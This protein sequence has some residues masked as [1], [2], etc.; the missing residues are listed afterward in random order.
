MTTIRRSA[1][2]TFT[3]RQMF[4]LVNNIADYP[5]FLPWCRSSRILSQTDTEI[6][7]SLEIAWSGVRKSF[8][9]RN[10]LYPYERID[11]S[12]AEGPFRHLEGHWS[13]I[14]CGESGCQVN[15]A[16]QFE[17]TGHVLDLVF[18]PVFHRIANSLVDAFCK[19]A[20]ELYGSY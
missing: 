10:H 1:L 13:F 5:R 17:L 7:A 15:L 11:I 2:V 20:V 16:L 19:R 3:P 9:T 12:L 8:T 6:E 14:S 4:E 18:Q